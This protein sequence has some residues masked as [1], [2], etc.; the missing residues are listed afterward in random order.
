MGIFIL[1]GLML[2]AFAGYRVY[3]YKK[4]RKIEEMA[5]DAQAYVSSEIVELLQLLKT[6]IAQNEGELSPQ[7]LNIQSKINFLTENLFC[8]TDSEASVRDYLVAAKQDISVLSFKLKKL[9]AG[10]TVDEPI[11]QTTQDAN[12]EILNEFDALK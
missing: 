6:V 11:T 10:E 7:L 12:P 3:L 4:Q 1:A 5:S 2:V 8:H 9:V